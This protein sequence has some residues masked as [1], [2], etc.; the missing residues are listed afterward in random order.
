[1]SSGSYFLQVLLDAL[2]VG[3]VLIQS[4]LWVWRGCALYT[5]CSNSPLI[6]ILQGSPASLVSMVYRTRDLM[7]SSQR[8]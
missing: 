5:M 1:M 8:L 4:I 6:P 3:T 2:S 7:I